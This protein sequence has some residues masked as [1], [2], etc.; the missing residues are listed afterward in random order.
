MVALGIK[1]VPTKL[2][3]GS[4]GVPLKLAHGVKALSTANQTSSVRDS[5]SRRRSKFLPEH[6]GLWSRVIMGLIGPQT[7]ILNTAQEWFKDHDFEL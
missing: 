7:R 3:R 5:G 6:R 2:A 1:Q 4:N